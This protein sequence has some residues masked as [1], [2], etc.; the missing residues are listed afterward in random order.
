MS[1]SV[2]TCVLGPSPRSGK[3]RIPVSPP[4]VLPFPPLCTRQGTAHPSH[5][6]EGWQENRAT[7]AHM[8]IR[9]AS[10]T[11]SHRASQPDCTTELP[12]NSEDTSAGPLLVTLTTAKAESPPPM[13][14]RVRKDRPRQ[15]GSR[16][17]PFIPEGRG[18]GHHRR[19]GAGSRR[20]VN[21]YDSRDYVCK[22]PEWQL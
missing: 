6:Q 22:L 4:R 20:T 8:E 14:P 17:W 9:E 21:T 12:G 19:G 13:S 15:P 18:R 1:L 3:V 7:Y 16:Q 11:R 5:L 2:C 10:G